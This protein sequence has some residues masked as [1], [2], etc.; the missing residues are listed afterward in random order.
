MEKQVLKSEFYSRL[1]KWSVNDAYREASNNF[2]FL[3]TMNDLHVSHTLEVVE[4]FS[5]SQQIKMF[6]ALTKNSYQLSGEYSNIDLTPEEKVMLGLFQ[7]K[8][9]LLPHY[10]SK[11]YDI[12]YIKKSF[13]KL[14][15]KELKKIIIR[16][17]FPIFGNPSEP[18]NHL[19]YMT[20]IENKW[21][22][23]TL[24]SL[25]ITGISYSHIVGFLPPGITFSN[26]EELYKKRLVFS[27]PISLPKWLGFK[28]GGWFFLKN[29]DPTIAAKTIAGACSHFLN[30]FPDLIDGLVS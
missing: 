24:V 6:V 17:L 9:E 30:A 14:P 12:F 7:K 27:N 26:N 13:L 4:S 29:E 1:Y 10:K 28:G 21:S 23:S 19:P 18:G 15:I 16:E 25:D 2:L 8:Q 20:I 11:L 3:K 5:K 22:I